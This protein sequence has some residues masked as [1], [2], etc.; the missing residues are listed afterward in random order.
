MA[1]FLW[2][3]MENVHEVKVGALT[4]LSIVLMYSVLGGVLL[5]LVEQWTFFDGFYYS[6][7]SCMKIGFGDI[8][9]RTSAGLWLSLTYR[10][11]GRFLISALKERLYFALVCAV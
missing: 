11:Y 3:H 7:I 1:D 10:S 6:F 8:M 9:P 2:S 4:V 5:P